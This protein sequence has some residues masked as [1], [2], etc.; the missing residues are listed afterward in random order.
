[1]RQLPSQG[2]RLNPLGMDGIVGREPAEV[3]LPGSSL[4]RHRER[5]FP[6]R[7]HRE[8][9][10]PTSRQCRGPVVGS[11]ELLAELVGVK[12]PGRA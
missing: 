6:L 4:L 3:Q 5:C 11:S 10:E 7:Q 2:S 1:M 8:L 12:V 9:F